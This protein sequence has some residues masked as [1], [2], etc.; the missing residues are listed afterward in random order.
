[1]NET[2]PPSFFRSVGPVLAGVAAV[3]I[4]STA[5]D[6]V[7][8]AIGVFPSW[9]QPMSNALFLLAT[10]YRSVYAIVGGFIAARF[11]PDRPM[12]HALALGVVG[13]VL[14]TVGAALAW[15]AGPK[16]YPLALIATALP[17][18]CAGGKLRIMQLGTRPGA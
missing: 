2:R 10:T 6:S 9:N 13:I 1:M 17:C 18:A 3:I 4:L 7:L 15:G 16:W 14:G 12:R 5:T 11:A 8:R